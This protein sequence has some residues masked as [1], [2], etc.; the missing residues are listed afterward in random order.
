MKKLFFITILL[1]SL[2]A[3]SCATPLPI[4]QLKSVKHDRSHWIQGVEIITESKDS[5]DVELGYIRTDGVWYIFDV[6]VTNRGEQEI[7]I[8]PTQISYKPVDFSGDTL[9]RVFAED[10]E[11][12]I[13]DEQKKLA[14][15]QADSKNLALNSIVS[16]TIE[17][18]AISAIEDT[19]DSG[20]YV[21][22][23]NYAEEAYRI[24]LESASAIDQR[25]YWET[26]ALRKTTLFPDHYIQGQV[27]MKWTKKASRIILNITVGDTEFE[28]QY[29]QFLKSPY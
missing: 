1:T 18:A 17:L 9:N 4:S 27:Y 21:Y 14:Q 24:D 19:D 5:I 6:W 13:L 15:L 8:E 10:P 20:D 28:F 29:R 26:K 3:I 12:R 22:D 23:Y 11:F 2:F 25:T 7:V 16:S